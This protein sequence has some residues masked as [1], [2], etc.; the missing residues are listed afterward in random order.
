MPGFPGMTITKVEGCSASSRHIAHNIREELTDFTPKVRIEILAP[1]ELAD[2]I[3]D[4]IVHI[5]NTG[6][7]GDGLVWITD[8]ERAV[9]IHPIMA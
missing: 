7:I 5:G 3:V 6:Q 2:P 1:P 8:V 4:R 9:F